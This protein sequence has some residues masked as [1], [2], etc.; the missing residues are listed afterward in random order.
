MG[1]TPSIKLTTVKPSGSMSLL[2][3]CTPGMH[4]AYAPYYIRRITFAAG[5]PLVDAAR[6]RGF[7]VEPRINIDGSKD[8]SSL[9]VE[10]P[11][12]VPEGTRCAGD[13]P[14]IDQ[15]ED[16]KFLQTHWA[17]NSV[18]ATIYYRKHELNAVKEWLAAN[19]KDGVKA[20]SFLLHSDHGFHQAPFEQITEAQ[21]MKQAAKVRPMTGLTD[22]EQGA[23]YRYLNNSQDDSASE[24]TTG[25]CPIK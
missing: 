19:Y 5:N 9:L 15:L 20:V 25:A 3:G 6:E 12:R 1:V 10:F 22:D 8:H 7:K 14:A 4:A 18:S 21:F 17:D 23:L 11:S 2:A 24:C 16:Q 13:Y